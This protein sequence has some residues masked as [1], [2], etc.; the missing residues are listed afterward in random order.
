M[1]QTIAVVPF[2]LAT[3]LV[4]GV[5]LLPRPGIADEGKAKTPLQEGKELTIENCQACHY[6]DG[7]DQAGTVGPP[8]LAMKPRFPDRQK[9]EKMIY[10]PQVVSKPYTMMPPFGRNYV[11]DEHQIKL[12]VDFLYT[13]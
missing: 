11:L 5:F 12:I 6:F 10:D 4:A 1:R 2:G 8:L 13:L 3:A 7:T 9:L